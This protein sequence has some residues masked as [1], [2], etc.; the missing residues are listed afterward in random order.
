MTQDAAKATGRWG[1][2]PEF[3]SLDAVEQN[4]FW[5]R[6][7]GRVIGELV[8]QIVAD[9]PTGFQVL[10]VGCGTGSVLQVLENVCERGH[11]TGSELFAEG[12]AFARQRVRCALV[13]ADIYDLPFGPQFDVVGLFDVLEHLA[14][15]E[16]AL[17]CLSRVLR[18]TGKLIMTVP[19]HMPLWS[20]SDVASGHYCRFSPTALRQA[21]QVTNYQ[22]HYL[23]QFMAPLYPLMKLG[24]ALAAV[25]NRL[26]RAPRNQIAL[27]TA[28]FRVNPIVNAV[29]SGLL[30]LEFPLVRRQQRLPIGTSLIAVAS[31]RRPD[32]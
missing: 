29:I 24:R 13:Q 12:L 32:S 15:P 25:H 17:R 30:K 26:R 20:Y 22:V 14:D 27:A 19:A 8:G 16:R 9:L 23:S 4:H 6:H 21:L 1:A 31:P 28:E 2:K 11:V 5:F 10:E 18:P 3:A 7:R